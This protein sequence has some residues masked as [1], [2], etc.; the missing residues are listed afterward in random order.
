MGNEE[1]GGPE[2]AGKPGRLGPG[3]EAVHEREEERVGRVGFL[4]GSDEKGRVKGRRRRAEE[5]LRILGDPGGVEE[6]PW[7]DRVARLTCATSFVDR[8]A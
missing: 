1:A 7:V 4:T 8:A 3:R 2:G 5:G 6:R